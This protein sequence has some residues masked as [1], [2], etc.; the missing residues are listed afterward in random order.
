MLNFIFLLPLIILSILCIMSFFFRGR[1]TF[2]HGLGDVAYFIFLY[3]STFI[4]C[5]I[6][7]FLRNDTSIIVYII[8]V[9][10][11][12]IS[13]YLFLKLSIWRGNEYRWDGYII[14]PKEWK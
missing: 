5:L 3:S 2:G 8:A 1:L 14:E 7:L 9:L 10:F 6:Y 11:L 12:V 13:I 4:Y